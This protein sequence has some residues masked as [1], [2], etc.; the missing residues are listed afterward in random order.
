MLIQ[1]KKIKKKIRRKQKDVIVGLK[2]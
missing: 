1:L 2:E